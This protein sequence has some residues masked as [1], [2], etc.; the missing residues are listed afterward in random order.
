M[1]KLIGKEWIDRFISQRNVNGLCETLDQVSK[2]FL[3]TVSSDV[4]LG[5]FSFGASWL[6][7]VGRTIGNILNNRNRYSCLKDLWDDVTNIT[8]YIIQDN[9]VDEEL[10]SF[11]LTPDSMRNY[12]RLTLALASR[13]HQDSEANF[14]R[15]DK[16]GG[17]LRNDKS[18]R[19]RWN[20]NNRTYAKQ[21]LTGEK[22]A[23]K[24]NNEEKTISW[25]DLLSMLD[26]LRGKMARFI[27]SPEG[28]EL[29]AEIVP[30]IKTE[31]NENTIK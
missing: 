23:I 8:K 20:I 10:R 2:P 28:A 25:F 14:K 7:A 11:D 17:I 16:N 27:N 9:K 19:S 30:H 1:T 26:K 29:W 12:V 21:I 24:Q 4:I 6:K 18:A 5:F 22:I 13:T 3:N 15:Y 31:N